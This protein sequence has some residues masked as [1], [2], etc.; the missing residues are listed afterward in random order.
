MLAGQ[1]LLRGHWPYIDVWDRKP[2]GLFILYAG[3]AAIGGKSILAMNMVATAFAASAAVVV[4]QI[5]L[6]F[7]SP[8]AALFAA[9][10]YLFVLPLYGGQNGQSRVFDNLLIAC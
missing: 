5:T 8:L 10:T 7:A 1:E 2:L 3:I 9:F 6:R 4:R